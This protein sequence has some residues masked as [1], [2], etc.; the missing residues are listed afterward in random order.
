MQNTEN[1]GKYLITHLKALAVKYPDV[2]KNVRGLG[3]LLAYDVGEDSRM[4][5]L[6]I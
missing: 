6:L 5:D 1:T 3:T 2:I 4:R